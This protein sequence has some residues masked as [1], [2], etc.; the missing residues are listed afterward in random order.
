MG[1]RRVRG[2]V[3]L[4]LWAAGCAAPPNPP[5]ASS[6]TAARNA[7]PRKPRLLIVGL[8]GLEPRLVR[9]LMAQGRLPTFR[10]LAARGTLTGI[11]VREDPVKPLAL[12]SPAAWTT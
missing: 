10:R 5:A 9:D 4:A 1:R 3:G 7:A 8:D 11:D 2:L 12:V 6:P